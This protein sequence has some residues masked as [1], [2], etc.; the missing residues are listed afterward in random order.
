MPVNV[1][2]AVSLIL[3]TLLPA[4]TIL[5]P[6][7]PASATQIEAPHGVAP[8]AKFN[9]TAANALSSDQAVDQMAVWS[10]TDQ[11]TVTLTITQA[12]DLPV[13]GSVPLVDLP[14]GT[15]N[16]ALLGVDKRPTKQFN[17]TDVIMIASIN[18]DVPAVTLLSIPRDTPVYIPGRQVWKVNTAYGE[19]G[20]IEL[21]KDT[22]RYNFGLKIDYYALVN[23]SAL[24][25]S[26]DIL[27]GIDVV[28][29]CPIQHGFPRDPYYMGGPYVA[30]DYTDTFTGEVWKAGSKVPLTILDLPKPGVYSLDGQHALAYVR[31]RKGIPGGD[32]DRGR[33][34]QRVVR[35]LFAKAKQLG[36]ITKIP[37]LLEAFDQDVKTD[38]TLPQLVQLAGVADRF[39]DAVIRSRFLDAQGSNGAAL[40]DIDEGNKYWRNRRDYVEQVLTVALNHKAEDGIPIEVLNGTSEPGFALAAADR[41]NELGFRVVEIKA[42]DKAYA[43]SVI[44]NHTTT[45][46][47]SAVPLLLRTFSLQSRNV[48]A[49]P[50]PEGVRYSIVVG[51][52]FNTCYY[53]S[54]LRASG[55]TPI[56]TSSIP[57]STLEDMTDTID[58]TL[59]FA[60][61]TS[62]PGSTVSP[63][64]TVDAN[65][66]T[67]TP[68]A[69]AIATA[70]PTQDAVIIDPA[71]STAI[72]TAVVPNTAPGG[73]T[74]EGSVPTPAPTV[75]PVVVLP[76]LNG[77]TAVI[78]TGVTVNVRR[79]PG[80][81]YRVLGDL[82]RNEM[83]PVIGKSGDGEWLQIQIGNIVG[84]IAVRV[85]KITGDVGSVAVTDG[86]G[87]TG[88]QVVTAT[89]TNNLANI[90]VPRGDVINVRRGPGTNTGVTFKLRGGQSASIIGQNADGTWL[91]IQYKGT[92]GWVFRTVVI[93]SG[94]TSSI[95]IIR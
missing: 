68:A 25:H 18:P 91:Q 1:K 36:T 34:E 83:V 38:L 87:G 92:T 12:K 30:Q 73:A 53:A 69:T 10:P 51:A 50:Q 29:T 59:P 49:D 81:T 55:S 64:A 39:S 80:T 43:Q 20:G 23:F 72:P 77:P 94:D 58:V 79:G 89:Q 88:K 60:T 84:W 74:P 6:I 19:G 76:P 40:T 41:L 15:I 78:N 62:L 21:F 8:V 14:P 56:D 27:G 3:A 85:A 54:S 61:P 5:L 9:S 52:D 71:A 17:N 24:V 2:P 4:I 35:A 7:A 82:G 16:I 63:E 95:P 67:A 37:E 44:I 90:V 66:P 57:I 75:A 93:A 13:P 32:V 22:I 46:K 65:Q 33:R 31:A 11:V 70:E 26:V 48:V 45:S 86:S 47:G 28:A 42:A